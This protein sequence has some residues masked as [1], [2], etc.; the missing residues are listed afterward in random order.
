MPGYLGQ[1][2]PQ[3]QF[4]ELV[5]GSDGMQ[6][7]F[8]HQLLQGFDPA[9]MFEREPI[10]LLQDIA[11]A[12]FEF[13]GRDENEEL[14]PWAGSWES[15]AILPVAVRL[16]IDLGEETRSIWPLLI[17]GVM[18]DEAAST[19]TGARQTY[20]NAIQSITSRPEEPE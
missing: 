7:Q 16:D 18:V 19:L 14:M 11:E 20:Q 15:P 10:I 8:S 12:R 1:G 9:F 3:V 5:D 13:L 6:L 4:L 17:A 2:G